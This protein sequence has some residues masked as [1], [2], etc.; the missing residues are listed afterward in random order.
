M[1]AKKPINTNFVQ[2][3]LFILMLW[4]IT[5]YAQGTQH[6]SA[7]NLTFNGQAIK[8]NEVLVIVKGM[9]CSFCAKGI[10][11]KLAK[12]N[13]VN[14]KKFKQGSKGNI[15]QQKIMVAIKSNHSANIK[16]IYK[17]IRSAGYTPK[18]AYLLNKNQKIQKYNAQGNLC[19]SSSC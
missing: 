13:F 16:S 12:L 15:Q 6:T 1:L 4:P 9:V 5:F 18:A 7:K 19:A 10:Q 11:K 2:A 14:K 17:A 3:L 8:N